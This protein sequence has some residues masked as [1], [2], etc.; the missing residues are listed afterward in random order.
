MVNNVCSTLDKRIT[1]ES[2]S[3]EE[4]FTI[5]YESLEKKLMTKDLEQDQSI[6]ALRARRVHQRVAGDQA[7]G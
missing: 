2:A 4:K 1:D 6:E 3:L 5:S 7:Q